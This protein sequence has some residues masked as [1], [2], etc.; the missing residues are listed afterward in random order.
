MQDTSIISSLVELTKQRDQLSI[1][2]KLLST[3]MSATDAAWIVFCRLLDDR[4][5]EVLDRVPSPSPGKSSKHY[6]VDLFA[7]VDVFVKCSHLRRPIWVTDLEPYQA[8][9]FTIND[10]ATNDDFIVLFN[11]DLDGR[12]ER[13]AASI[14]DLYENFVALVIE[15]TQDAL[16]GLL[17]RGAFDRDL[18]LAAMSVSHGKRRCDA[19]DGCGYLAML[20]IDHFKRINDRYGHL[21]GDEVLLLFATLFRDSFRRADK[22]YRYGG[23]EF[24]VIIDHAA[25]R[26]VVDLLQRFRQSVSEFTFPQVGNVTVSIGAAPITGNSLPSNIVDRAD[27]ALYRAKE[28]GRDQVQLFHTDADGHDRQLPRRDV[29]LF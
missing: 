9:I 8:I 19:E 20:D 7:R 22:L 26:D 27:N 24:A 29:E 25:E 2:A 21:Y 14:L 18:E 16:T 15:N 28:N 5:V 3:L 17:N 11:P 6:P 10:G 13:T 12:D 23:E 4:T 1:R